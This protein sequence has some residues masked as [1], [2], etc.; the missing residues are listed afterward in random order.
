MIELIKN[1]LLRINALLLL[2]D[3]K[4]TNKVK[5]IVTDNGA[6]INK[7]V[8]LLKQEDKLSSLE[9]VRC[10]G[11]IINLIIKKVLNYNETKKDSAVIISNEESASQGV[12]NDC[13]TN[14]EECDIDSANKDGDYVLSVV[15]NN[16]ASLKDFLVLS[17]KWR[18]FNGIIN[19]STALSDLFDTRQRLILNKELTC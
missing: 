11:H 15:D 17:K 16:K 10:I 8:D 3:Y 12:Q 9:H 18:R 5:F 14:N 13:L 7:C 4:I 19:H 2:N 6:N 1:A